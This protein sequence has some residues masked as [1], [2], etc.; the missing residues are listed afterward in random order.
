MGLL[1]Q[2]VVIDTRFI[3]AYPFRF[4][5]ATALSTSALVLW[6]NRRPGRPADSE[7]KTL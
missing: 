5:S 3:Y 1:L 2:I 7:S 6:R 4:V